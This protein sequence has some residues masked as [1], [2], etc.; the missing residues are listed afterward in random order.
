[1]E[2]RWGSGL[3]DWLRGTLFADR[4]YYYLLSIDTGRTSGSALAS[5]GIFFERIFLVPVVDTGIDLAAWVL[6]GMKLML[7]F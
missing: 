1:M 7:Q 6:L 4:G 2:V 5:W 3:D